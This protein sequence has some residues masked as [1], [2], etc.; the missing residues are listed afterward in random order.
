MSWIGNL[1]YLFISCKSGNF[2]RVEIK[3]MQIMMFVIKANVLS[4]TY[5]KII[6]LRLFTNTKNVLHFSWDT[7]Y[8]SQ[9]VQ[10]KINHINNGIVLDTIGLP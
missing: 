5:K 3:N 4:T 10:T 8:V 1:S 6:Y 2:C 9:T 7:L